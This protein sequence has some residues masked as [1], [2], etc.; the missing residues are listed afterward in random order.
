MLEAVGVATN[1]VLVHSDVE[2][3]AKDKEGDRADGSGGGGAHPDVDLS[4]H[5]FDLCIRSSRAGSSQSSKKAY[6][7]NLNLIMIQAGSGSGRGGEGRGGSGAPPPPPSPQQ[8]GVAWSP[9]VY[10][11]A[12]DHVRLSHAAAPHSPF[13]EAG[14]HATLSPYSQLLPVAM[15]GLLEFSLV[16]HLD[17]QQALAADRSRLMVGLV[18]LT[19]SR[20]LHIL[21]PS[22]VLGS[23]HRSGDSD[24][25]NDSEEM[26]LQLEQDGGGPD[27]S[28]VD[29]SDILLSARWGEH[30]RVCPL[31]LVFYDVMV[32]TVQCAERACEPGFHSDGRLP[33]LIRSGVS[34]EDRGATIPAAAALQPRD[35][36]RRRRPQQP[37]QQQQHGRELRHLRGRELDPSGPLDEQDIQYLRGFRYGR[38]SGLGR[39]GGGR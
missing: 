24:N 36:R 37:Q 23:R 4:S 20:V 22:A 35:R 15:A 7:K 16:A 21:R 9:A 33:E 19:F 1:M 5:N 12:D 34:L 30:R 18:V 39:G 27:L 29:P 26:G 3:S 10:Q 8:D 25:D 11:E 32:P 31:V 17:G 2:G 14:P 38:S 6:E 28:A 13:A